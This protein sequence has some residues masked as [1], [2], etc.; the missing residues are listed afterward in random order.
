L[1]ARRDPGI[2]APRA[3]ARPVFATLGWNPW[4]ENAWPEAENLQRMERPG[5]FASDGAS[6][7]AQHT[8]PEHAKSDVAGIIAPGPWIAFTALGLG[9]A[10]DSLH[11]IKVIGHVPAWI[12]DAVAAPLM[13]LGGWH[14]YRANVVFRRAGTAFQ[15]WIPTTTIAAH[16]IYARTRN[17]MYQGFL[18]LV[19]GLAILFRSDWT[20][21]LLIPAALL[22][23]YGV[24]LREERY[25][26]RR[27]GESY[28]AYRAAVPR[29]GWPWG[30]AKT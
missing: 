29:Y 5:E 15:P 12:R 18:L 30:R 21:I 13:A 17:P 22:V 28:E 1:R 20:A 14:I 26:R 4:S 8:K 7:E 24:V 3:A 19:L 27:F 25:L 2:F 23:H 10:F 9:I 6:A 16:G 11:L